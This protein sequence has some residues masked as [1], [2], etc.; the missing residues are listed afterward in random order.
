MNKTYSLC[1]F[2]QQTDDGV[3]VAVGW[4]ESSFALSTNVV[5][6]K[7]HSGLWNI[8]LI[9]DSPINEQQLRKMQS[10]A[11]KGFASLKE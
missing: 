4:I 9:D 8:A 6:L 10:A 5:E 11:H 1:R 3:E 7:G 2:E